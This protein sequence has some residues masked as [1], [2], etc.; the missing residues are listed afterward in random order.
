MKEINESEV[1]LILHSYEDRRREIHERIMSMI[2]ELGETDG[3]IYEMS[4]SSP[5]ITDMPKQKGRI[6]DLND[7]LSRYKSSLHERILEVNQS[8]RQLTEEE[9]ALNR[10]W[11][12]YQALRGEEYKVL[13]RLFVERQPWKTVEIECGMSSGSLQ[14]I[15]KRALQKIIDMYNSPYSITEINSRSESYKKERERECEDGGSYQQLSLF[16]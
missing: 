13:R 10:V 8:I 5:R 2:K 16:E 9:E 12:C 6:N 1:K 4:V 11:S 14:R 3:M 7:V 15:Q